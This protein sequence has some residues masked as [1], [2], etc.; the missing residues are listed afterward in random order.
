MNHSSKILVT[1]TSSG[2]GNHL[3]Q[4][5]CNQGYKVVGISRTE[6]H[7]PP[8]HYCHYSADLSSVK[9]IH[10]LCRKIYTAHPDITT[11]I[12]NAGQGLICSL[13]EMADLEIVQNFH[14]N[15]I[16]P[17]LLSKFWI[18]LFKQKNQGKIICIGSKS[19]VEPGKYGTV[20]CAGKFGLRGFFLS[21]R[22]ECACTGIQVHLIHPG[23]VRTPFFD[24][25]SFEPTQNPTSSLLVEDTTDAIFYLLNLPSHVC[26]EEM[27][28]NPM[29]PQV[30]FKKNYK[31]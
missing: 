23:S 1:G 12:L 10:A 28:I 17:I 19:A 5:L 27:H 26:V 9:E 29:V 2:I 25:Q 8:S 30:Q 15:L 31:K 21:L 6:P 18:P 14:L 24:T 3:M 4:S 13:E 22:Q 11:L 16:A 20:Y 7:N